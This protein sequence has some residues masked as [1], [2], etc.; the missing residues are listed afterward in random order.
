MVGAVVFKRKFA[1]QVIPPDF[2]LQE[3]FQIAACLIQNVVVQE[4][5]GS[6]NFGSVYKGIWNEK[7]LV[8]LKKLNSSENI[9]QFL[10]EA[11][12]LQQLRHPNIV[13]FFGIFLHDDLKPILV[14]EFMEKGSLLD[15]L[16][17]EGDTLSPEQLQMMCCDTLQGMMYLESKNIIHRD[18]AAR[19]LLIRL[20]AEG[21][22]VVKVADFGMG[23][24][25]STSVY[26]AKDSQMPV[27]VRIGNFLIIKSGWPLK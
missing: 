19:N 10:S 27:K 24:I 8:A 18:L 17:T 3:A 11:K 20:N 12:M 23:K 21:Q 1:K 5:L 22:Y 25:S 14:M 6:G 9:Q 15:L 2:A 16:Q 26:Y 13:Q 7:T 4:K